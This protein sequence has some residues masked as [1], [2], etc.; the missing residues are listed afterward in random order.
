M[1]P[2]KPKFELARV[3]GTPVSDAELLT[4]L[5]L[6][7]NELE[8][9]TVP[10]KTYGKLGKYDYSTVIRHFGSW[11]A[12]L[13]E[14]GLD[15]S[16]EVQFSD[17][18]LFENVLVLWQHFGR[19]PRRRELSSPPS[20]ISQSPYRRRFGSWSVA[21]ERFVAYANS[22]EA[23]SVA[24]TTLSAITAKR[25]GRDPSPRL[26]WKVL[27][28]DRFTCQHCGASPAKTIGVDLHVDHIVPWIRGGE[29]TIENLQTLC[30][31][32]NL[33]KGTLDQRDETFVK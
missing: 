19:Q 7:A 27:H 3:S 12:A 15:L 11:N 33:G 28:R 32:C 1:N 22:P 20:T 16:N 4:D 8:R 9:S 18:R 5:K 31:R 30:S 23:E 26:R 10:Q 6:V 13:L 29:T 17:E 14:A 25:T 21:L 24:A 2:P